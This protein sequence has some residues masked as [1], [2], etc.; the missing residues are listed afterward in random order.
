MEAKESLTGQ[1]EMFDQSIDDDMAEDSNPSDVEQID[2]S[3]VE[4]S[5]SS[6]QDG[7]TSDDVKRSSSLD[8][9]NNVTSDGADEELAA[10]D[11]KLAQA[12][13]TR[14]GNQDLKANDSS[15]SEEDMDDEQMEAL[16]GHLEKIFKE[17]KMASSK[18]SERKDAKETIIRFK[19]RVLELLEI[20]VKD[21]TTKSLAMSLLT[22]LLTCIRTTSSPLVSN[23]ACDV[24]REYANL[25]KGRNIAK[26][27]GVEET[28]RLLDVI[29]TEAVREGSNAHAN[30]CSQASLLL[31]RVL[32]AHDRECLRRIVGIYA[33]TQEKF[34]FDTECKIKLS[35]FSDWLNYCNTARR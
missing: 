21:Q 5:A 8:S 10:F 3:D 33:G 11:E 28:F 29:H 23:K 22:P 12:L 4:S 9:D 32:V 17:T 34:L 26:V 27:E 19:C 13:R 2:V 20:F 16:D 15:S 6:S 30:A 7:E 1:A 25:C 18:K 24:M 35:F 31:V 14:P